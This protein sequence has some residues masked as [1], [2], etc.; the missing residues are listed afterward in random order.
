MGWEGRAIGRDL[1]DGAMRK[2]N[3]EIDD[4]NGEERGKG[5]RGKV[6]MADQVNEKEKERKSK[7]TVHVDVLG[8]REGTCEG[9]PGAFDNYRSR[10]RK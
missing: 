1:G 6:S 10:T 8:E 9:T 4:K 3:E 7:P 5:G 2:G